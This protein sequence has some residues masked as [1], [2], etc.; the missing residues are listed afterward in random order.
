MSLFDLERAIRRGVS[1]GI[2]KAVGDAIGKAI[3]PTATDL[4]NKAAE[5]IDNAAGSIQNTQEQA[6]GGGLQGAFANLERSMSNYATEMSKNIKICPNCEKPTSSD[7]KF[8]PECGT[9]LPEQTVAEGAVCTQCGKQNA[10]GTKFCQ[11]C[12]AKLPAAIAEEQAA[13]ERDARVLAEWDEKLPQYPKWNCGGCNF[14]IND[15]DGYYSF[16]ADFKGNG[17]A[18]QNAV[19]QYRQSLL[20]NGFQT[21]GQHPS[22]DHL[23]KKVG[24]VCYHADTE[25]CFEGD[26]DC[27]SIGFNISEPYGG[28]DY[29]KPEPKQGFGGLKDLFGF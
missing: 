18:A 12:G 27:P 20:Q 24:G 6:Q 23:Y 7:K 13:A 29:V 4:A 15:Y 22:M 14:E 3:E 21:A 5:Q 19:E 10:I 2:G 8:C 17:M 26:P 9:P 1:Q 28:F 11:D 25:H 16:S